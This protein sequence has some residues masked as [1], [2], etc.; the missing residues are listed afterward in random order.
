MSGAARGHDE[1]V[2]FDDEG[3]AREDAGRRNSGER[4][5][6]WSHWWVQ[7]ELGSTRWVVVRTR[8]VG[9]QEV[10]LA[11][12]QFEQAIKE[13]L[14]ESLK[15]LRCFPPG[16]SWTGRTDPE[17]YW[18]GLAGLEIES[19]GME[20]ECPYTKLVVLFR[21]LNRRDVL[22]GGRYAIWPA[23]SPDPQYCAGQFEMYLME[24]AGRFRVRADAITADDAARG[25]IWLP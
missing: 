16:A 1:R 21:P 24:S 6:R 9:P 22:L 23:E 11:P 4:D 15:E 2:L 17:P 3:G 14:D 18:E 19:F 8:M 12:R 20:G 7:P 10:G 25:P 5:W 13:S